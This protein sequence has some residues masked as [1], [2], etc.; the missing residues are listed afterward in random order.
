MQ[1]RI[2]RVEKT[3]VVIIECSVRCANPPDVNWFK[4]STVVKQDSR[5]T[6]N[7]QQ[8]TKVGLRKF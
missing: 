7:V 5:R 3:K 2:V 1:P 6:V 4:E 8:V